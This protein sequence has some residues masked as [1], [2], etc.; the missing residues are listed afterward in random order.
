MAVWCVGCE[1]SHGVPVPPAPKAWQ[2]NGSLELPTFSPSLNVRRPDPNAPIKC[3]SII[4]NGRIQYL[5]DC[6]HKFA[7]QTLDLPEW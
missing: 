5:S 4:T 2:W 1:C 3:H 6:L 7:G